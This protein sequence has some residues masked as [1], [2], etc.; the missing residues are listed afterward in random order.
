VSVLLD[1]AVLALRFG[2]NRFPGSE[3][4]TAVEVVSERVRSYVGWRLDRVQEGV[5]VEGTRGQHLDT[6]LRPLH[7]VVSVVLDGV[8]LAPNDC[9][10]Y[11][12]TR[13]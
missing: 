4:V 1:P 13:T 2:R 10:R 6:G 12:S 5:T 9:H 3:T 7:T 8:A 11:G